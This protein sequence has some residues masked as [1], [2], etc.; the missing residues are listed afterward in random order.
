MASFSSTRPL[1]V[2][3]SAVGL[4]KYSIYADTEPSF[5]D[6]MCQN[7]IMWGWN[8]G[9]Q[10][11]KRLHCRNKFNTYLDF[12]CNRHGIFWH[13]TT[14][15]K[16]KYKNTV[17]HTENSKIRIHPPQIVI[18]DETLLAHLCPVLHCPPNCAVQHGTGRVRGGQSSKLGSSSSLLS[19][20][21]YRLNDG[22]CLLATLLQYHN[23]V[24]SY[25][26]IL[27]QRFSPRW[28]EPHIMADGRGE[29]GESKKAGKLSLAEGKRGWFQSFIS[30]VWIRQYHW[31]LQCCCLL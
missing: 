23:A 29:R 1:Y 16:Y 14:E 24:E 17:E 28:V 7:S 5:C 13:F 25:P 20:N 6:A 19:A 3:L 30:S 21:L 26:V 10:K 15:E 8:Y 11:S 22:Q 12:V 27:P 18:R 31:L 2:W 4:A 9:S